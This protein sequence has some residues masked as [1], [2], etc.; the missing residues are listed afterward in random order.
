MVISYEEMRFR[1]EDNVQSARQSKFSEE[2]PLHFIS[3]RPHFLSRRRVLVRE[4]EHS[5]FIIY[6]SIHKKT[7]K[8]G[9]NYIARRK[10]KPQRTNS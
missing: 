2:K 6:H 10:S 1:V 7:F 3:F 8:L 9:N 4:R 5:A